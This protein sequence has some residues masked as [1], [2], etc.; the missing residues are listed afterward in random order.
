MT[1]AGD[2]LTILKTERENL[3][4]R[5]KSD[6]HSEKAK[7]LVKI[8]DLEDDIAEVIKERK[9]KNPKSFH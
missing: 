3:I 1:W 8:M 9:T 2:R 5:W 7:I 4:D 6:K